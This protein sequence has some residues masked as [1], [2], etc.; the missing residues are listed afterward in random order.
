M[1]SQ[2]DALSQTSRTIGLHGALRPLITPGED[3]RPN[4]LF[5][6]V[7]EARFPPVYET[8]EIRAWRRENLLT[9][10]LLKDNGREFLRHYCNSTA[11]CPS[12]ATLFTGQYPSLHGVTQT[13]GAAKSPFDPDQ[14]WLD[15]NT[16]PIMGEYFRLA[17]YRTFYKGKWHISY[18]DILV[19]GTRNALT[20]YN[21]DGE[22]D[23]EKERYYLVADHLGKFGFVGWVG[24]EP[25]GRNPRNSGSSAGIGVSGRDVVYGGEVADLILCLEKEHQTAPWLIV[26]SFVNPHDI[27][28]FGAYTAVLP[29]F[30]FAVEDSIPPVPP[31]PTAGESLL[32]KPRAQR[33]YRRVYHEA[34]QPLFDTPLYRRLYFQLQKNVDRDLMRV[35]ETLRR[36]VFYH[37]TIVILTSDHGDLLGAHGGLFQKFYCAYEEVIHVP[38]ILHNPV[39][40]QGRNQVETLTSHIDLLPTML[41]LAG[42]DVHDVQEKLRRNHTEVHTLVGRNLAPLLCGEGE[43]PEEP[44]YFM[45]DD[46]ITRGPNQ[47]T[48]LGRHYE[49]VLQPNHIQTV[50]APVQTSKGPQLWKFSAYYDNPQF[51]TTPGVVDKVLRQVDEESGEKRCVTTE[52]I[53]PVPEEFEMYN[54]S[55]DPLE[56]VNLAHPSNATSESQLI[57]R[58]LAALLVEQCRQKRLMPASGTVAGLPACSLF[59]PLSPAE[60]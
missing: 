53:R 21:P 5:L 52:K 17:G 32:T 35:F 4:F 46:D 2:P 40:F 9:Q 13:T 27:V 23:P 42:I 33:S 18:E 54:L 29:M 41:G 55:E 20:S 39:L 43:P 57:G 25:H 31:A 12:R 56:S 8:P 48:V 16:V 7:D 6:M 26:A 36:S 34:I 51:W 22:P 30:K 60:S 50:V 1:P 24:P 45:T 47:V 15:P 14:F 37:D 3:K 44:V 49:S 11:C 58:T 38:L 28:L 10:E 19:P 59:D